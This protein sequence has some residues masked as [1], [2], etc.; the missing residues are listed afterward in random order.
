MIDFLTEM[1]SEEGGLRAN[2]RIPIADLL[3]T[4]TGGW[5]LYQLGALD[6]LV[7]EGADPRG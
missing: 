5:T 1:R 6:R 2:G 4:F 3:S 7:D